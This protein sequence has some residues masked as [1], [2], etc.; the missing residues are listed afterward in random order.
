M[1]ERN[2][3]RAPY[4]NICLKQ[5]HSGL[6]EIRGALSLSLLLVNHAL[7]SAVMKVAEYQEKTES[8]GNIGLC[9]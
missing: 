9:S 5:Y 1:F 8:D 4:C 3:H 2:V 6:S 7:E